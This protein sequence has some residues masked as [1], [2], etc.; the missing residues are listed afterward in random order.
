MCVHL[1]E[2]ARN[3]SSENHHPTLF[4]II[5]Y[6]RSSGCSQFMVLAE[7]KKI[8]PKMNYTNDVMLEYLPSLIWSYQVIDRLCF[9]PTIY[10]IQWMCETQT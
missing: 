2:A 6:A 1:Y 9:T 5:V 3:F 10:V 8:L 7:K 4:V